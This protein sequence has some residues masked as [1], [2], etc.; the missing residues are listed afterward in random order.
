MANKKNVPDISGKVRM[1]FFF[2]V[3]LLLMILTLVV[4]I[5]GFH[6]QSPFS[7]GDII[8]PLGSPAG[9]KDCKVMNKDNFLAKAAT[10]LINPITSQVNMVS[11]E[12]FIQIINNPMFHRIIMAT[13]TLYIIIWGVYIALGL[14]QTSLRDFI[15]RV[16]KIG[17]VLSLIHPYSF[18]FFN[19]FLFG[20]FV[21]GSQELIGMVANP[22]CD[23][24][25]SAVNYFAFTNYAMHALFGQPDLLLRISS[26]IVSFPIGWLCFI[27]FCQAI[28]AY[29]IAILRAIL[30]YLIAY[31]AVG[32][33]ISLGPI[34]IATLLFKSTQ[35]LFTGWMGA[36]VSFAMEPVI[37][38]ATIILVTLFVNQALYDVMG[39]LKWLPFLDFHINLK[40]P[41]SCD[42]HWYC[43]HI[44]NLK[45]YLPSFYDNTIGFS[46]KGSTS[47]GTSGLIGGLANI[48]TYVGYIQSF[49]VLSIGVGLLNKVGEFSTQISEYLFGGAG[50]LSTANSAVSSVANT[51]KS[52][53][54]MDTAGKAR[55]KEQKEKAD[56]AKDKADRAK[57]FGGK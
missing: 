28:F 36:L 29:F 32:L 27:I 14:T 44:I 42:G 30:A 1:V 12:V 55:R 25:D 52:M 9:I 47:V 19:Q 39:E 2:G 17:V 20:L 8:Q 54:G 16:F 23:S 26:T 22:Y 31:T 46:V 37:L 41:Q 13:L 56:A 6:E 11:E 45:W 15:S 5:L 21:E 57:R 38:F 24:G 10:F 51:A 7:V 49:I 43:I 48:E 50:M 35:H 34:F 18:N 53:V 40:A 33:V 3:V 4:M